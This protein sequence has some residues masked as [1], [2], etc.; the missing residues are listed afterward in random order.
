MR[1]VDLDP[2]GAVIELLAGGFA[3]LDWAVDDL[4][5]FRHVEFGCVAFEVVS[6]GRGD[7]AR[8]A[9]EA[10]AG[11][12]AFGDG[13]LDFDVAVAGAFGFEIAQSCKTLFESAAAGEGGAGCAEGDAGLEDVGVVA[14]FGWVF[15][16]EKDVGVG[17][18]E[19][20]EDGGVGEVD[21]VEAGGRLGGGGGD[22]YDAVVLDDDDLVFE[23]R[24]GGAVDEGAG[25]DDGDPFGCGG[26]RLGL[27]GVNCCDEC[28]CGAEGGCG[29]EF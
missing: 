11:N 4:H 24:V 10:R 1:H 28:D 9:E 7:A 14:A 19:A 22:F 16:P 8:G 15:A 5:A 17:V 25:A 12:G 18:D 3:G 2:V 26:R 27:R 13:F 23:R 29:C 6:A 21:D 20:G